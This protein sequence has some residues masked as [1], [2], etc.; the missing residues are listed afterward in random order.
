M[1]KTDNLSIKHLSWVVESRTVLQRTSLELF[2][3]LQKNKTVLTQ[4]Q[5]A[6]LIRALLASAFSLWR[7]AFLADKSGERKKV[8]HD[9]YEFL[10]K[11]LTDNA[12]GYP[13]DRAMREWSY[14][15]Y[16]DA[17]NFSLRKLAKTWPAVHSILSTKCIEPLGT[18]KAHGRWNRHHAAFKLAVTHLRDGLE[19]GQL[20]N[21]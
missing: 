9:G 13:Q 21:S 17:A 1:Q 4:K 2:E 11:I 20:F 7:A 5:N 16:M 12:I 18:T 6:E 19:K 14:D 15:Y 3:L 8:I 10:G